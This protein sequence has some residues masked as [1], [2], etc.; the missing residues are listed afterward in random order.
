MLNQHVEG[1]PRTGHGDEVAVCRVHGVGQV[2]E[3]VVL[4]HVLHAVAHAVLR[5]F[6]QVGEVHIASD[7]AVP[8][9]SRQFICTQQGMSL[10]IYLQYTGMDMD[11]F[12]KRFRVDFKEKFA[13]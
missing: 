3:V 2:L 4:A 5:Q 1:I 11:A 9:Q 13:K 6:H 10:D 12:R 8:G 7:I